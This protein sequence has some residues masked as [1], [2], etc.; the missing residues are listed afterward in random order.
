LP[1]ISNALQEM[2]G[3]KD[4]KEEFT[5]VASSAIVGSDLFNVKYQ[6]SFRYGSNYQGK[7]AYIE[8]VMFL[9]LE[10]SIDPTIKV[11]VKLISEKPVNLGDDTASPVAGLKFNIIW[12]VGS[13][14]GAKSKTDSFE[15]NGKSGKLKAN[16]R[17]FD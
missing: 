4:K 13:L 11:T 2:A 12:S 15:L 8:N 14:L 7:G 3:G 1:N 9:P 10:T 6:I 16:I 5:K 17:D